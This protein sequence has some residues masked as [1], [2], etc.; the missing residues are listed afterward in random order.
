M[1]PGYG[2]AEA[3]LESGANVY[4]GSSNAERV[5]SA[6]KNLESANASGKGSI[7]GRA[8]DLKSDESVKEFVDWVANDKERKEEGV[9]HLIFTAGDAL[10]L[11]DLMD[12]NLEEAKAV[13]TSLSSSDLIGKADSRGNIKA[14]EVRFWGALRVVKAVHPAMKDRGRFGSITLTSV[15]PR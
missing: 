14:F 9:D 11:G 8:I 3:A 15:R 1:N 10:M 13:S 4:I 5:E 7:Q 12:T 2:A 6:V